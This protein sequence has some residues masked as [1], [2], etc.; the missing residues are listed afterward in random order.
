MYRKLLSFFLCSLCFGSTLLGYDYDL[1]ISMIFQNE[2]PYLKEWIEYHRLVG[3]EHFYLFNDGSTDHYKKVLAPYISKGIV[4]LYDA[5]PKPIFN[6]KQVSCYNRT[7]AKSRGISKWV[8]MIDSDEFLVTPEGIEVID[9]LNQFEE[10]GGV[11]I[12]WHSFGTSDVAKIPPDKLMIECL[13]HCAPPD[14]YMNHIVKSIVRPE[15]VK[16]F[17]G[18]H[19]PE[20]AEDWFSVDPDGNRYVPPTAFSKRD[21]LWINHYWARDNDFLINIKIPRS[22]PLDRTPDWI[23]SVAKE[24]NAVTDDCIL[25]HVPALRKRVFKKN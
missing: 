10:F 14:H 4:E 20:H 1:S 23:L 2:A 9:V 13:V 8:A 22:V 3:V 16:R 25:R 18:P 19:W 11:T 12:N 17:S 15:R 5:H 21:K 24:L 6:N 7:L